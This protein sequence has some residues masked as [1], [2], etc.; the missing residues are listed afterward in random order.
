MLR[1]I[2][3]LCLVLILSPIVRAQDLHLALEQRA[4][5][6]FKT[7]PKGLTLN[8][9]QQMVVND[10]IE[11]EI[12]Y[13]KLLQAQKKIGEARAQFF[14][15]GL[16]TVG[17]MYILNIWNPILLVELITS[18]PSKVYNV[19]SERNMSLAEKYN[20][21]ALKENIKNQVSHLY[22]DILR[23][24]G[25]LKLTTLQIA[26]HES[27]LKT[28][29]ERVILGLST[30]S[31]VKG[32]ERRLLAL[33]D[34]YL[35]FNAYLS[36]EKAAFN[37]MIAKTPAEAKTI[38]LQ[39]VGE[40]LKASDF[41]MDLDTMVKSA[42]EHSNEL[43]A[44]DYM[45]TAASKARKSVKWSIL[46]FNGIGFGYWS[47]IQVAGSQ[48]KEAQTNRRIVEENLV[49]QVYVADNA[50]KRSLDLVESE[51]SILD[52]TTFYLT[53]EVERFKAGQIA[54]N[55]LIETELIYLKDFNEL[56]LAHYSSL[57]KLNDLE[58][59]VMD[60]VREV[61][62]TD[63]VE[64]KMDNYKRNWYALTVEPSE[65]TKI[66][67]VEYEFDDYLG[68]RP[69]TSYTAKSDFQIN[70]KLYSPEYVGG[71]VIVTLDNGNTIKQSFRFE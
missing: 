38:E 68:L 34:T 57:T 67:K 24:E 48:I 69:M 18:I 66:T 71:T 1:L 58:R 30:Q 56:M 20:L 47:R 39:P 9:V 29:Q 46:S 59:V 60:E 49:N 11:V 61:E 27:L 7:K 52:G 63:A 37:Q 42:V 4:Q 5:E 15:Y 35:K 13:E 19:Q 32:I 40:F 43:V 55:D 16:G 25:A 8:Q 45:I 31:D 54:L 33:R 22:Y 50:F 26:L 65:G 64:I 3:S 10:D 44:A 6:V 51:D 2:L 28:Y 62:H 12:A 17:A 36:V 14:P 53:S 23:E 41:K 21:E 70:L